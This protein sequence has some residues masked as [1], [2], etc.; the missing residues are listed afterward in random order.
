MMQQLVNDV[1]LLINE[2]TQIWEM[3]VRMPDPDKRAS[4]LATWHLPLYCAYRH[5]PRSLVLFSVVDA[6][7]ARVVEALCRFVRGTNTLHAIPPVHGP[8]VMADSHPML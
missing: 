6:S 3:T 8:G 4:Q 2:S 1:A 7:A 5:D